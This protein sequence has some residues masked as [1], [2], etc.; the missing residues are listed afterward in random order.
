MPKIYCQPETFD[1]SN[2]IFSEPEDSK[3]PSMKYS[4]INIKT[5]GEDGK[6]GDLCLILDACPSYGIGTKFGVSMSLSLFN[7]DGPTELQLA[8][9]SCLDAITERAKDICVEKRKALGKPQLNKEQL[10]DFGVVKYKYDDEGNRD[11]TKSPTMNAKVLTYRK[12]NG[13]ELEVPK[14]GAT[15]VDAE[16]ND[17][18]DPVAILEDKRCTV[19][20]IIH[21]TGIFFG[22]SVKKLQC[23]VIE[24]QVLDIE[25]NNSSKS[26][27]KSLRS[28]NDGSANFSKSLSALQSLKEGL[29]AGS[30]DIEEEEYTEPSGSV[31]EEE[32]P[33]P[34]P[35]PVK[36]KS[37]R[38]TK[39]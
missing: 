31:E 16:C 9:V 28:Q 6:I 2:M 1:V 21:V 4:R 38:R 26:Y 15:F 10:E 13:V 23:K 33:E 34:E 24:C 3:D 30:D 25:E 12:D 39:K 17:I 22:T 20:C 14:I 19:R 35:E 5:K 18:P 27:F 36:K 7:R 29:S 11:M 8:V 32:E 37:E